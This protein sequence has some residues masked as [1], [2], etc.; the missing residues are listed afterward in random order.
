[1][2]PYKRTCHPPNKN[3]NSKRIRCSEGALCNWK[4]GTLICF[5]A[6]TW[7][8]A[9]SFEMNHPHTETRW[10]WKWFHVG[11]QMAGMFVCDQLPGSWRKVSSWVA[12][13]SCFFHSPIIIHQLLHLLQCWWLKPWRQLA[14]VGNY[15][16]WQAMQDTKPHHN[17]TLAKSFCAITRPKNEWRSIDQITS[18]SSSSSSPLTQTTVKKDRTVSS[19]N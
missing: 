18:Q 13:S 19:I 6:P 1:M 9:K 14:E 8:A 3:K 5:K 2:I 7:V 15:K 16:T 11:C 10:E 4:V 12:E 17:V